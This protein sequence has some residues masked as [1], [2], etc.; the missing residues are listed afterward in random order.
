MQQNISEPRYSKELPIQ[1]SGGPSPIYLLKKFFWLRWFF[2][3]VRGLSL[4]AA[5]RDHPLGVVC[6]LLFTFVAEHRF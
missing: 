3:A 6:R 5:S 1:A 2:V 4:V